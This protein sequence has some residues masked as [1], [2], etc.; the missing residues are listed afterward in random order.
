M[1]SFALRV[2]CYDANVFTLLK[3]L[4]LKLWTALIP[5]VPHF[6]I[7]YIQDETHVKFLLF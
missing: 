1:L 5:L 2:Y 4:F 3:S 7:E 6:L